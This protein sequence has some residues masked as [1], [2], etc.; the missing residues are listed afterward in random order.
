MLKENEIISRALVTID[1]FKGSLKAFKSSI[2]DGGYTQLHMPN[3]FSRTLV[4]KVCLITDS[5]KISTWESKLNDSRVVFDQLISRDDMKLPWN[6]LDLDSVFYHFGDLSR[7]SSITRKLSSRD[8]KG[9]HKVSLLRVNSTED[10]LSSS[11]QLL[12]YVNTG[13]DLELLQTI[14]LDIDR[15]FPGEDFFSESNKYSIHRKKQ[16]IEI[17]YLW[18]KCNPQV[19]YK[20]GLH[21]ILGLIYMNLSQESVDISQTNTFSSDDM[22]ILSLYNVHY[23]CHDVFTIF[24]KFMLQSGN[25]THFYASE[26]ALW[27]SIEN[28]NVYLMKIDQFIHYTLNTKLNLEPQLWIIRYLRLLLLRELGSDLETTMLLWDKLV[29]LQL[30]IN[31][32]NSISSIPDILNF[33]IIQLL[34]QVKTDILSSDFSEC[35]SI[36][37]HYPFK[38]TTQIEK[39]EFVKKLFKDAVKLYEK[40]NDD[41]KLYE[42]GIR[43]NNRYNPNLKILMNYTNGERSSTESVNSSRA[44]SPAPGSNPPP[45]SAPPSLS[46]SRN[47]N[48][49]FEKMRLEM[50]LKK[51]AQLM[52]NPK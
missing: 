5:F 44:A 35:L 27:K 7:K 13:D 30:P 41:L 38:P 6:K 1:N 11:A 48:M 51:K 34:I 46:S 22:K 17:L 3:C 25:I 37:L 28:F 19:G 42:C 50:R 45:T 14:I 47:D 4:W 24:N 29:S 9:L 32:G 31:L 15:L 18:S 39:H 21:E 2:T 10:P 33:M 12:S 26:D 23:L 43:L 40:R 8:S 52:I 20:Q 16:L 36:L 49:K